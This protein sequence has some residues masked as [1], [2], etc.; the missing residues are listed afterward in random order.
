M[1]HEDYIER[2]MWLPVMQSGKSKASVV[3]PTSRQ[4]QDTRMRCL[5][6]CLG[7]FGLGIK[8]WRQAEGGMDHSVPSEP[9]VGEDEE[10]T[11]LTLEGLKDIISS[12]ESKK[13][14]IDCLSANAHITGKL[15]EQEAQEF[16]QWCSNEIRKFQ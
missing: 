4:V 10:Q 5:V 13:Q 11:E 2:S 6:K 16:R 8:L 14:I 12:A 15:S 7:M 3:N 9:V 1:I